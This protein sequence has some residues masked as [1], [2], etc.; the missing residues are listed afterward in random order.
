MS[1]WFRMYDELLDDP[2]VQ[3]L[4]PE[5]FRG[6]VNLLCLASRN[7]GKLPAIADIAFALRETQD[8]VS[9]LIERLRSGGLIERRSGGAD[10]AFD[11]PYKWAERQYKSDTSTERVKRFRKRFGNND[12]TPSETEAETDNSEAKASGGEPPSDPVKQVF[13]LGVAILTSNGTAEKHARSMIGK[14]CKAKGEAQVLQALLDARNRA[15]PLE[16]I[17]AR[18][19]TA[20]YVSKSG[21]EYRG[22]DEQ[23]MREAER[24]GDNDTYWRAK[25]SLQT[26]KQPARAMQ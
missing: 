17:E 18:F 23:V 19:K 11:A 21:Y 3:R 16:W 12:E 10:G 4:P 20:K 26:A 5:D 9:T 8:A 7:N 2:K 15:S 13:D 25:S 22:S 6:W 24:R 1:R 14:W